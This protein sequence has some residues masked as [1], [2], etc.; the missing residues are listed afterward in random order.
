M[1]RSFA[2]GAPISLGR[3]EGRPLHLWRSASTPRQPL[4]LDSPYTST[5]AGTGYTGRSGA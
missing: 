4:H 5:V 1:L 3:P 2:I